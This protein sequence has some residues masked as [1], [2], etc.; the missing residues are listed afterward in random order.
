MSTPAAA[1]PTIRMVFHTLLVSATALAIA[2]VS[3]SRGRIAD[4]AGT[5]SAVSVPTAIAQAISNQTSTAPIR[6]NTARSRLSA[7]V[8]V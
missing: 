7:A 4:C 8:S 6:I 3:I 2:R 1:G 5:A